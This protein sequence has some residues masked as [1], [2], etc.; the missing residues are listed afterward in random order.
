MKWN[1]KQISGGLVRETADR[2]GIDLLTASILHRREI[3]IP[4]EVQ[5]FLEEDV[6][7][8]HNPFLFSE[9]EDAVDRIMAA[10]EEGEKVLVFGDRDVDGITSITLMVEILEEM[11]IDVTWKLPIGDDPYSLTIEV[12]EEFARSGGT[13]IITVDCGC[14]N[15][16]EI[17]RASDLGI[18]TI[19]VD[20]HNPQD[21]LPEAVAI[22]NPKLED[23]EY[24]FPGLCGC[25]VVSKLRWALRF[26]VSDFYNKPLC[27]LNV[28]P[29]NDTV[30]IDAL[31]VVNLT[32]KDRITE[33]LI[34]G[35]VSLEDTRLMDF[36]RNQIIVYDAP[37][38]ERLLRRLFGN[39]VDIFLTDAAEEIW[40]VFPGLT[41][42]SLLKIGDSSRAVKY[43]ESSF[44]EID[45]LYNLFVSF[46]LSKLPELSEDT[47]KSLDLVALGT[48]ADIMPLTNENRILV[49]HGLKSLDGTA[50]KG[51]RDL[52]FQK[53]LLG[54]RITSSDIGWQITPVLNASGRMGEPDKAVKLLLS[55]DDA[56]REQ[57][58][59]EV[60]QLNDTRRQVGD[61][62]WEKLLPAAK[63]SLEEL[64]GKFVLVMDPSIHRG[65]TG[66]IASRLVKLFNVPCAALA[67]LDDKV[68]GSVRSTRG[69]MVQEFLE[70][71]S[72]LLEDWGGHDAAGGFYFL[73]ERTEEV[74]QAV[75]SAAKGIS[76]EDEEEQSL[77]IDAEIPGDYLSPDIEKVVNRLSPYGEG[78]PPLTFLTTGM[79]ILEMDL[80]GRKEQKH[81]KFLL[82]AGKYRWPG[83]YWRAGHRAEG[84]LKVNDQVDVVYQV[85]KNYFNNKETLQLVVLDMKH[86]S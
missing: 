24:P 43:R 67:V 34:P 53:R 86:S 32:V 83:V 68:I 70:P 28:R 50:R 14:T 18:D 10:R 52:L 15:I 17:E 36:F 39:G 40:N 71:L 26:A 31:K 41:N 56:E 81:L 80:I 45:V 3:L 64:D 55:R 49:R 66:I 35:Y 74:I 60:I 62:A 7:Y 57:L 27:L 82:G 16:T 29:G 6:R 47:R 2:Y 75:K 76:L 30:I 5:F 38:Q 54:K 84:D 23:C 61:A 48:I 73:P 4:G 12:V 65:V 11:G 44:G 72:G 25:G 42:M 20:H 58:L 46:A 78:N 77:Q 33:N 79:K 85:S 8:L 37:P 22:I 9:M 21:E 1:K 13:L 59:S 19:V 51:L 63:E 69:L